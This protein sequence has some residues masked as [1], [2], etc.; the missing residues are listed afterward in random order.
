MK[1][2]WLVVVLVVGLGAAWSGPV[3]NEEGAVEEGW[4]HI[5]KAFIG[6]NRCSP[7]QRQN[8]LTLKRYI[9]SGPTKVVLIDVVEEMPKDQRH[10]QPPY[11]T[12][13]RKRTK[14]FSSKQMLSVIDEKI[15]I[16]EQF[17]IGEYPP[18]AGGGS[19][20]IAQLRNDLDFWIRDF[21][22]GGSYQKRID[23]AGWLWEA[24]PREQ[25]WDLAE[26][27]KYTRGA[28]LLNKVRLQKEKDGWKLAELQIIIVW[29]GDEAE[30]WKFEK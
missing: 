27:R 30:C 29:A 14:L 15:G 6:W 11:L 8:L 7:Q 19:T 12:T 3:Q 20:A 26:W 10:Y 23:Q 1:G 21:L 24:I 22:I 5:R 25:G 17:R 16:I 9:S 28:R 4:F 2:L 13:K 18:G